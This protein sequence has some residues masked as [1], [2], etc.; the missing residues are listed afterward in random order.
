MPSR[1]ISAAWHSVRSPRAPAVRLGN[2]AD[3]AVAAAMFLQDAAKRRQCVLQTLVVVLEAGEGKAE[4]I[5]PMSE[6]LA[7]VENAGGSRRR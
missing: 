7:A 1:P 3:K 2:T 4:V 5:E 6:R